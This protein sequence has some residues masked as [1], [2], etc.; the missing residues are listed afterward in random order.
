VTAPAAT[1]PAGTAAAPSLTSV[2]DV[3]SAMQAVIRP[4]PA[5]DGVACFTRLYLTV[6]Q[7]VAKRLATSTFANPT[8]LAELDVVFARLY[9]EA[10]DAA[11]H[12]PR[13]I[14][15]AWAPLFEARA[16]KRIAPLQFALAGMNAH[17]N[18]DLPV[19]LVSCC[20]HAG[21]TLAEDTPEHAD[22]LEINRLLATVERQIKG[23]YL[24][25]WLH[26]LDRLVH[27]VHRLDDV[28]A[29]WDVTQ[30]RN[31]A[32]TNAEALWA[33]RDR[34][35]LF[36]RYLQTLDHTV[37]LASRGLLTPADTWLGKIG[38]LRRR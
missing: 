30:A 22:Y 19:A 31:A 21:I 36:R 26:T 6:T 5:S 1:E 23:D 11:R 12:D 28:V 35:D 32:W 20:H 24:N 13:Q 18:R 2:A 29:M 16:R 9:F 25:G 3:I 38:R 4:L 15:P 10:V 14:P 37:G 17:I 8:F 34:P 27:R 33:L 7:D